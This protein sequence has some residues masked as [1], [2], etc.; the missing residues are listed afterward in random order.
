MQKLGGYTFYWDPD[1]MSMPYSEKTVAEAKTFGGSQVFEW[2][3]TIVGKEV[4]LKWDYMPVGMF[5]AL[6]RRFLNTGTLY[7]WDPE[8]VGGTTYSVVIKKLEGAYFKHMRED[9]EWRRGVK[10]TLSLRAKV[11]VGQTTTT[12]STTTTT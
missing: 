11:V 2:D 5:N 9:T 7:T 8:I 1:E 6:R 3:A 12:T 4:V 10:M